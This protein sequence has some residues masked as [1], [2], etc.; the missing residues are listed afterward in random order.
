MDDATYSY[1]AISKPRPY[2]LLVFLTASHPKFKC[3]ICRQL[4]KEFH[5]LAT[6]YS[7]ANLKFGDKAPV[8]FIRLD[9]E[10]SQRIFQSYE[11]NTVPVVFHIPPFYGDKNVKEFHIASNDKLQVSATPEAEQL[12][13]FLRERTGFS[14]PIKRNMFWAYITLIIL[15]AIVA[16]LVKPFIDYLPVWLSFIQSVT[17]WGSVSALIYTCA[18]SGLIFDI[19][20]SPPM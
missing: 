11:I 10:S 17:L 4:D 8:F 6:S 13:T 15:F 18:I 20:R 1:Y 16:F 9:Y 14:I 7:A 19:I 3:S 2:S 5:L 12:A